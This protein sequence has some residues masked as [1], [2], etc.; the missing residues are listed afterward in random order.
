MKARSW[1][2][3]ICVILA[4]VVGIGTLFVRPRFLKARVSARRSSCI[5]N[6]RMIDAAKDQYALEYLTHDDNIAA[7]VLTSTN[8][9]V[10]LKD[11][12]KCYCPLSVRTR[13][14]FAAS[15]SINAL[16]SDPTCIASDA[17]DSHRLSYSAYGG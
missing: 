16:T 1:I 3:L 2:L 5:S 15:Y 9:A 11:I 8:I 17:E 10:Y 6:L 13:R 7:T 14:T 4:L 12:D